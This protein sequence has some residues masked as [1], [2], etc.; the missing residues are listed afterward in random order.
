MSNDIA[1]ALAVIIVFAGMGIP[2]IV[3]GWIHA[4][5]IQER[6]RSK[7]RRRHED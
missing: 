7:Q 3:L 1:Q 6:R 4:K 2:A 5:E